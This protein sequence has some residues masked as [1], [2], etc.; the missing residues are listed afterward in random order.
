MVHSNSPFEISLFCE[1]LNILW[2]KWEHQNSWNLLESN[3]ITKF[4]DGIKYIYKLCWWFIIGVNDRQQLA[5]SPECTLI[6]TKNE[7][8]WPKFNKNDKTEWINTI[9]LIQAYQ[10]HDTIA[11][12]L[13]DKMAAKR[14]QDK[15][16]PSDTLKE[17]CANHILKK[18]LK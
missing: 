18:H 16:A 6:Y 7:T 15:M 1:K 11:K 13:H 8:A 12:R 9:Y 17:T 5:T 3:P 10:R 14:L 4:S 2:D